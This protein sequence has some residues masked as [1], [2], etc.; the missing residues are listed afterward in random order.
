MEG[1]LERRSGGGSDVDVKKSPFDQVAAGPFAAFSRWGYRYFVLMRGKLHSYAND[2]EYHQGRQPREV[3]LLRNAYAAVVEVPPPELGE[4][5]PPRRY[6][7]FVATGQGDVV[8]LVA[9]SEE[10]VLAWVAAIATVVRGSIEKWSALELGLWLKAVQLEHVAGALSALDG[11]QFCDAMAK[12]GRIAAAG[13]RDAADQARCAELVV[14]LAQTDQRLGVDVVAVTESLAQLAQLSTLGE[15]KPGGEHAGI[16][17]LCRPSLR[18]TAAKLEAS[19]RQ[20]G[21]PASVSVFHGQGSELM[22]FSAAADS[23]APVMTDGKTELLRCYRQH[24][25][26][27]STAASV[28]VLMSPGLFTSHESILGE[29]HE[30]L[31]MEP[32]GMKS[33]LPADMLLASIALALAVDK[34]VVPL[35][36]SDFKIPKPRNIPPE[37][38]L[39]MKRDFH[40]LVE[41]SPHT[42]HVSVSR[43]LEDL[44]LKSDLRTLDAS[45]AALATVDLTLACIL[46]PGTMAFHRNCLQRLQAFCASVDGERS[47]YQHHGVAAVAACLET[48]A[49]DLDVIHHVMVLFEI[50]CFNEYDRERIATLSIEGGVQSLLASLLAVCDREAMMSESKEEAERHKNDWQS[51]HTSDLSHDEIML[52]ACVSLKLLARNDVNLREMRAAGATKVMKAC[53]ASVNRD[54]RNLAEGALDE[55]LA[56]SDA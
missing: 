26:A 24:V 54:L 3:L 48:H 12:P 22:S 14:W 20:H 31:G 34:F 46:A 17:I 16:A 38:K 9:G 19:M 13:V 44:G 52:D 51:D 42:E 33:P 40:K 29:D 47:F 10:E 37:L 49:G 11:R 39:L 45:E 2:E 25:D 50:L 32:Y 15:R 56:L 6:R 8:R 43:V 41:N 23:G 30:L 35:Y 21:M 36:T 53:L 4:E 28:I 5:E 27:A 55:L 18:A 1:W 7:F